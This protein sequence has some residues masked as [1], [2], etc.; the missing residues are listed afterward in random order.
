MMADLVAVDGGSRCVAINALSCC[1]A[2]LKIPI[3]GHPVAIAYGINAE[4]QLICDLDYKQ[5]SEGLADCPIVFNMPTAA[6]IGLQM[7]GQMTKDQ[8]MN[9]M[10][11]ALGHAQAIH[12]IHEGAMQGE[13]HE[14]GE[15]H[16]GG[17]HE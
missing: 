6:V 4:G 10:R 8:F 3:V 7:Q 16:K 15:A 9:G 17:Q 13:A 1:L 5:D 11:M 12:R 14:Q 2:R